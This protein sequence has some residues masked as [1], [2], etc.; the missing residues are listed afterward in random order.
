MATNTNWRAEE[1]T[2]GKRAAR[3]TFVS[4]DVCLHGFKEDR[5]EGGWEEEDE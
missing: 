4:D 2:N 5:E 3:P 1:L